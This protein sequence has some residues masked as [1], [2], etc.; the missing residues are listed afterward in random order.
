MLYVPHSIT[1]TKIISHDAKELVSEAET[2]FGLSVRNHEV[3]KNS[4]RDETISP[5]K[6]ERKSEEFA[7]SISIANVVEST[8]SNLGNLFYELESS[9]AQSI[10]TLPTT[11]PNCTIETEKDATQQEANEKV[12]GCVQ[13]LIKSAYRYNIKD[14]GEGDHYVSIRVDGDFNIMSTPVVKNSATPIFN[15]KFAVRVPHFRAKLE[16][17]LMD[18]ANNSKLGSYVTTPYEILQRKADEQMFHVQNNRYIIANST[19]KVGHL[20]MDLSMEENFEAH[21]LSDHVKLAPLSPEEELSM[22]R[23]N[24][25][26]ARF[27]A[28]IDLLGG[29]YV[30]YLE[31]MAWKDPVY[32]SLLFILFLICTIKVQSEYVLSSIMF[33]LVALM[34]RSLIRR[35]N[36]EYFK[37]YAESEKNIISIQYRPIGWLRIEAL[38]FRNK[39]STNSSIISS[40]VEG[41]KL[42]LL[43]VMC[44]PAKEMIKAS[45][46]KPKFYFVGYLNCSSEPEIISDGVPQFVANLLGSDANEK[47]LLL[48]NIFD[49]REYNETFSSDLNVGASEVTNH[50]TLLYPLLE[51]TVQPTVVDNTLL[52]D[53][54]KK[55]IEIW[56][57]CGSLIK[58]ALI[59]ESNYTFSEGKVSYV[60]FNVSEIVNSGKS[61][62][63]GSQRVFE[64]V[65]WFPS[66]SGKDVVSTDTA[67]KD[68]L[69]TTELLLKVSLEIPKPESVFFPNKNDRAQSYALQEIFHSAVERETTT[70]SVLWN[71]R[72]NVRYVQNLMNSILN[73]A[74]S[75]KNIFN[76]TSPWKTFIVYVVLIFVWLVTIFIPGR[77]IILL[78][79]FYQF[80]FVLLP[81][82]DGDE[83]SIRFLNLLEYIPNDDDLHQIYAPRS[84]EANKASS[85]H[86]KRNLQNTLL[87]LSSRVEWKGTV[88]IKNNIQHLS[89]TGNDSWNS[90]FIVFQGKRLIWWQSEDDIFDGKVNN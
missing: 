45:P 63:R 14:P 18:A 10:T 84:E 46:E 76:W 29:C 20:V 40:K 6:L 80:F 64:L 3:S 7:L 79:G 11:K 52:S 26:V 72:D 59:H 66:F 87:E 86:H 55:H 2:T 13:V 33:L 47:D 68:I 4:Q 81:I 85:L 21:F 48:Q 16:F 83:L 35:L 88:F 28:L 37:K 5:E 57:N 31:I 12:V 69:Q 23:L 42:P 78:L 82:P 71:M 61:V 8:V 32:T 17:S 62:L 65:K 22:D 19:Q 74:E 43:K 24:Q 77:I 50:V 30:A 15:A 9:T 44:M 38:A 1:N 53:P 41:S 51:P 90:A 67:S 89:S 34:T 39:N 27:A 36:G 54:Y 73:Y 70:L 49:F 58:I 25:H 75:F 60:Q 56:K